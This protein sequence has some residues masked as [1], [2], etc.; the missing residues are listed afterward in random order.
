ML[1]GQ[2]VLYFFHET[3][4]SKHYVRLILS[5]INQLI[6]EEKSYGPI[7]QDNPVVHIENCSV[8]ALD[9]VFSEHVIS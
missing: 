1:R 2:L 3:L 9:E 6:D 8:T 7:M 4:N 5:P